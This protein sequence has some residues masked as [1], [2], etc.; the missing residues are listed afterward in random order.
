M[1]PPVSTT[2]LHCF[3]LINLI[4]KK[5]LFCRQRQFHSVEAKS[6]NNARKQKF[7]RYERQHTLLPK[8][9]TLFIYLLGLGSSHV[10]VTS[11]CQA[12]TRP[13]RGVTP[14]KMKAMGS[15]SDHYQYQPPF[16]P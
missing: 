10:I 5:D 13:H 9:W 16:H 8:S 11:G 7:T 3:E 6:T 2:T 4:P 1:L 15:Q 12:L 14:R